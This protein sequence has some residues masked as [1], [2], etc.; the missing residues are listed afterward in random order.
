MAFQIGR[1]G[2]SCTYCTDQDKYERGCTSDGFSPTRIDNELIW[3][4]P[5]SWLIRNGVYRIIDG[6]PKLW[7]IQM[8]RYYSYLRDLH[9]PERAG[10]IVDQDPSYLAAMSLFHRLVEQE[11]ATRTGKT[12]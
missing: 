9:M 12:L 2:F 1:L 10:G 11:N 8:L 6:D 3:R 4:C 5:I 7:A